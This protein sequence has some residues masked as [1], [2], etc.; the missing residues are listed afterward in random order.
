MFKV[1]L[2]TL[3]YLASCAV[4]F[5]VHV[6]AS[7][8]LASYGSAYP[9]SLRS[10]IP[11]FSV[12]AVSLMQN[13]ALLCFGA[14]FVSGALALSALLRAPSRESKLYWVSSL[15][16]VNY[17]VGIFLLGAVAVGFFWLPKLASSL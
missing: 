14:L 11:V 3:F 13:S 10:Q 15:A 7:G 2:A 12:A 16:I 5:A 8:V 4:V 9:A 17:H 6:V 1:L